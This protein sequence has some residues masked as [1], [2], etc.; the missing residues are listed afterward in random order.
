MSNTPDTEQS[1]CCTKLNYSFAFWFSSHNGN[2]TKQADE[3]ENLLSHIKSF[4]TVEEFWGIYQHM[5]R[6]ESLQKGTELFLFKDSIRPLWED[7]AN[8]GGGKLVLHFPKNYSNRTWEDILVN[9]LLLDETHNKV[10]GCVI[11][12]KDYY[13]LQSIWLK[14]LNGKQ[15]KD[16]YRKWMLSAQDLPEN[17]EKLTYKE[18]PKANAI[19]NE[20]I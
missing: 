13:V 3:Y 1:N 7:K 6:P 2:K 16:K 9:L 10:N 15:E 18:F 19:N 4:N 12:I 20:K 8:S 17:Y 11:N 5:R 14:N